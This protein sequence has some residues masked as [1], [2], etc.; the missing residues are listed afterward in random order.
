L[1]TTSALG[2]KGNILSPAPANLPQEIMEVI[3]ATD[4]FRLERIVSTGQATP[5]G[6]WYDQETHEWVMLLTGEA[7]LLFENDPQL[8]IM[9]PGDYLLIP[10]HCRHRVE[11]TA[12]VQSTIWL[13]VHYRSQGGR[14]QETLAT[15]TL[16]GNG[17]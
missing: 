1:L 17:R 15:E 10:A 11:W 4:S 9:R 12:P 13:A 16:F 3:L 5:A 14:K 2:H 7:G 6:E 8:I